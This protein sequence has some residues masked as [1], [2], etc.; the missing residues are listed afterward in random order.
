MPKSS[1]RQ[2]K[3]KHFQVYYNASKPEKSVILDRDLEMV[4]LLPP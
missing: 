4:A 3:D 1:L 2:F